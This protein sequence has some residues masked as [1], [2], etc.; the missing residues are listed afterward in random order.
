[1]LIKLEIIGDVSSKHFLCVDW[2]YNFGSCVQCDPKVLVLTVLV[3]G[4][5][6]Q[7]VGL[8]GIENKLVGIHVPGNVFILLIN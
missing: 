2:F 7:Q 8:V 1:M 6:H 4:G 5:H 3:G